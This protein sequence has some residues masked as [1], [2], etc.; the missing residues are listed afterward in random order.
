MRTLRQRF[1]RFGWM[2]GRRSRVGTPLIG[3]KDTTGH[4]ILD[5]QHY[6]VRRVLGGNHQSPLRAPQRILDAGCGTGRWLVEMA[7]EFPEAEVVGIDLVRPE[8]LAP[9]L[10][11]LGARAKQVAFVGADLRQPLPFPDAS[12]DFAHMQLM[13]GALSAEQ[14]RFALRELARVTR[15]SG[16]VECVEPAEALYHAGPAYQVLLAWVAALL[17]SRGLDPDL[18]PKLKEL[19]LHAGIQQ[20][21]ERVVVSFP[22]LTM[23]RERRLWQAQALGVFESP[24]AREPILAAGVTTAEEYDRA[25]AAARKEFASGRYANSDVLY[26]AYGQR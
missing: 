13:H 7:A 1:G 20:V 10:A 3:P 2:W 17:Q 21:T 6:I 14:Y 9:M 16:W 26:V 24:R 5:F 19:L 4:D 22:N 23:T 25:L 12:V 15:S 8:S 18:G 11:P